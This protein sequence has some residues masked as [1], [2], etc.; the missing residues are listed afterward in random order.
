MNKRDR[1]EEKKRDSKSESNTDRER[2]LDYQQQFF[3][4]FLIVALV[5]IT[6]YQSAQPTK[7]SHMSSN[8]R[9]RLVE[10]HYCSI[11]AITKYS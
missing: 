4:Y 7:F 2:N 1:R 8:T 10:T 11:K 5:C 3:T 9:L 6:P